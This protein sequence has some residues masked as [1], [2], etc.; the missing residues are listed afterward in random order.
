VIDEKTRIEPDAIDELAEQL[1]R[2]IEAPALA[3][4]ESTRSSRA[5][6]D[7]YRASGAKHN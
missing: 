7:A 3:D 5:W 6:T 1:E 4:E 2:E